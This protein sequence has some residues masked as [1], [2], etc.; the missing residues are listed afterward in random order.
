MEAESP[1]LTGCMLRKYTAAD[2]HQLVLMHR[3]LD[4]AKADDGRAKGR[5]P[6]ELQHDV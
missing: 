1:L 2:I 3:S 6:R 4:K 5:H